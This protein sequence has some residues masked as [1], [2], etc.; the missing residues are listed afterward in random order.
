[1][2]IPFYSYIYRNDITSESKSYFDLTPT[3]Y[4]HNGAA[5]PYVY[6]IKIPKDSRQVK[7]RF[8]FLN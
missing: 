1:M 4:Y 7:V 8:L 2:F 5:N 6:N 3:F